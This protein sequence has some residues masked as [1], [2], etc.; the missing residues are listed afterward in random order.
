M[1]LDPGFLVLTG[2][3]SQGKSDLLAILQENS[4]MVP[5]DVDCLMHQLSGYGELWARFLATTALPKSR[6]RCEPEGLCCETGDKVWLARRDEALAR[7]AQAFIRITDDL[8]HLRAQMTESENTLTRALPWE[9]VQLIVDDVIEIA[10][11]QLI[12]ELVVPE[13]L[14]I[15]LVSG[16]RGV[17]IL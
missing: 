6:A 7:N 4:R 16:R 3:A 9:L 10:R 12:A 17:K 11:G 5:F 1:T 8:N 13:G 15:P 2:V 14:E